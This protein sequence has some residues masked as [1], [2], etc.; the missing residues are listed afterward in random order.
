[1]NSYSRHQ[2]FEAKNGGEVDFSGVTT[3]VSAITSG[4]D[5]AIFVAE[6]AG[7]ILFSALEEVNTR[8]LR[9]TARSAGI[10]D[11]GSLLKTGN[12]LMY[13]SA[14]GAGSI[15]HLENLCTYSGTTF[16]ETNGGDIAHTAVKASEFLIKAT[17]GVRSLGQSRA[18]TG[19]TCSTSA[20][21]S[22]L[23]SGICL[24]QTGI[25]KVGAQQIDV[26]ALA[27][28]DSYGVVAFELIHDQQSGQV[29]GSQ[30]VEID[31]STAKATL[32][33]QPLPGRTLRGA[34]FVGGSLYAID[35]VADELL[36]ISPA[37]GKIIGTPKKLMLGSSPYDL[38][39]HSDLV[40]NREANGL[41]TDNN[42]WYALDIQNGQLTLRHT[43]T[44]KLSDN[45]LPSFV[46]A[47]YGANATSA[48]FDLIELTT[49][50]L[51][52]ILS[53]DETLTRKTLFNTFPGQPVIDAELGDLGSVS[54][55]DTTPPGPVPIT[56]D[57]KGDGT[58]VT[59]DW[60][61]YDE[62]QNGNDINHYTV[63]TSPTNFTN[64]SQAK[65]AGTTQAG[66][67][68][69]I[70]QN[71]TRATAIYVAVTATDNWNNVNNNVTATATT[72]QD[73]VPPL[74][75][76]N[77]T[78]TSNSNSIGLAWAPSPSS[79]IGFYRVFEGA[80]NLSGDLPASKTNFLVSNLL[81]E[82]GYTF[83]IVAV[84]KSKNE[85]SG[86]SILAATHLRNPSGVT[87]TGKNSSAEVRWIGV[88]P[89]NLVKAYNIYAEESSYTSVS[90]LKPRAT[91]PAN[92]RITKVA[93][94]SNGKTYYV[95]VTTVNISN[96]ESKGVTTV[97][98]VPQQDKLGPIL[99]NATIQG[100]VLQT[101]VKVT[102]SA[103][104]QV[105]ANDESGV[106]R[107]EFYIND[108]Q[109]PKLLKIDASSGPIYS[110]HWDIASVPDGN[111]TV[112]LKAYDTLANL[113]PLSTLVTVEYGPPAVPA[114]TS[115]PNDHVTK[116][117]QIQVVGTAEKNTKV[118][119]YNND[120]GV[121]GLLTVDSLGSFR[122]SL[123]L[124][125]GINL[126]TATAEG[127]GG[128]S[129][130][131]APVKV[132]LDDTIP[133]A[134]KGVNA[135]ARTQG[136]IQV[137]WNAVQSQNQIVYDLYRASKSFSGLNGA[138]KV[139]SADIGSTSYVDL[140]T[141]DG[142]YYYRVVAKNE[143]NT[144]SVP[145]EQ[146]LADSDR[147]APKALN[148]DYAST[149]NVDPITG[150]MAPGFVTVT[151]DLNEE[152]LTTPFF[153]IAPEKD[154]PISVSL[155][156]KSVTQY[157]GTFEIK[158]NTASGKA[159]AVFAARDKVG[160]RGSEIVQG[161]SI[162]IDTSGPQVVKLTTSPVA[163]IENSSSSPV[164]V[165]ATLT[166]S[167]LPMLTE[168]PLVKYKLSGVG[169]TAVDIKNLTTP[170]DRKIWNA[171]F[172]LPAD[173]G[174]N[175]PENINFQF[176]AKD[177][178]E[179]VSTAIMAPNIFQVYQGTLP[180]L[181]V[182]QGL[183]AV[184]LPKGEV[185]LSW[186]AV[187]EAAGYQLFRKDPSS[188]TFKK[189]G[190]VLTGLNYKDAPSV[191]GVYAYTVASV[192]KE[193][194]K[195]TLSAQSDPVT[196]SADSVA[197]NP[198]RNLVLDLTGYGVKAT[199]DEPSGGSA[200]NGKVTY[201]FYRDNLP[202]NTP[203]IVQGLTPIV[204]KISTLLA[205]DP[206]PSELDHAYGVTAVDG[207][208]NESNPSNTVYLNFQLLP[209]S[210][211]SILHNQKTYPNISWTYTGTAASTYRLSAY[212]KGKP[213]TL[214]EGSATSYIDQGYRGEERKY[215]VI[216]ID[217]AKAESKPRTLVLPKLTTTYPT[218]LALQR[219]V[220]NR[221]TYRVKNNGVE[222]ITN[223]TLQATVKG[224]NHLSTVFGLKSQ[225]ELPVVVIVGGS[226]ALEDQEDI[227]TTIS[228]KPRAGETVQIVSIEE[229]NVTTSAL[230]V[231][232][233]TKDMKHG[234]TGQV[235]FSLQNTSEV[236]T[237]VITARNTGK[238]ASDEVGFVLTDENSSVYSTKPLHQH[239]GANVITLSNGDTV[240]RIAPKA[241]FTSDWM[242]IDVPASAPP[243]AK[244]ALQIKSFHSNLSTPQ[245]AFIAGHGTERD[246]TLEQP[247]YYGKV[248][249]IV[250]I[251]SFGDKITI[252]GQGLDTNTATPVTFRPL[253]LI[254][255][256]SGFERKISLTTDQSGE[257]EY[258][259]EPAKVPGGLYTVS[260]V[261][262]GL[263][264]RPNQGQFTLHTLTLSE[265]NFDIRTAKN[266]VQPFDVTVSAGPAT[267]AKDVQLLY[268]A[269]DQSL[270][271]LPKGIVITLPDPVDLSPNQSKKLL[272]KIAGDETAAN[273]GQLWL[274]LVAK[275]TGNKVLGMLRVTYRF[276][277]ATPVIAFSP[278]FLETG[279]KHNST[280]NETVF[281]K[282][283]GLAP[284]LN[285]QI[286]LLQKSNLKPAP[287]WIYTTSTLNLTRLGVGQR[288]RV[289]L[290]IDP[291]QS[292]TEG[293]HEFLLRVTAPGETTQ[294]LRI[295]VAVTQKGIGDVL[296]HLSDIYTGTLNSKQVPIPGLAG[297]KVKI[298][299]DT[300][301][302]ISQ[303][304]YSDVNGE[305][306]LK[307]LPA[308]NYIVR[309]SAPD[310]QDQID[311]LNIRAGIT[312]PK[313]LFLVNVVVQVEWSIKEITLKD[314]Y[315]IILRAVFKTNVP[316]AVVVLEP[317][318][319]QLPK[320]KKGQIF[321]GE[322][323][324]TNYGL[325]KATNIT[326]KLPGSDNRAKYEFFAQMPKELL[327][328]ERVKIPYR[329]T[330]LRD[331]DSGKDSTASGGGNCSY[332]NRY[333]VESESTCTN[334]QV[335]K[336]NTCAYWLYTQECTIS[337]GGKGKIIGG[338]VGGGGGGFKPKGKS[339]P[340]ITCVPWGD[341]IE[342]AAEPSGGW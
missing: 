109:G 58:W 79:D 24:Q 60:K 64:T 234:A 147:T 162:L 293:Y 25:I 23:P 283:D 271:T 236:T 192:R 336:G 315:Q 101:G 168:D 145:S 335:V 288:H 154:V 309:A 22:L 198:P 38:S 170:G 308:G 342:E 257:F 243:K 107:V 227:E 240:A 246:V 331:F 21:F 202:P 148:I 62:K 169:R 212:D 266:Y 19:N 280:V 77:I 9:F 115:P 151:I 110:A 70:L 43:D 49:S 197:P 46:G 323:T 150:R 201:A 186:K 33:G 264:D 17:F 126:L 29:T 100:K 218:P 211:I 26:D 273:L 94:L 231:S 47:T 63:Y 279:A 117:K 339:L 329:V 190:A 251:S 45:T 2:L 290:V 233:E 122:T 8:N 125:D 164:Q 129:A 37:D 244:I 105:T 259:V 74:E 223:A 219:G 16:S 265:T 6:S 123:Q 296:F 56:I 167:E 327:P 325:I 298:Q 320:M 341:C 255:Q 195:E 142:R 241:T 188:S 185:D 136:E 53:T 239:L 278:S 138:T 114:I 174:A 137:S 163:P 247:E 104:I 316:I 143:V 32:T 102:R 220:F 71:L 216:A 203:I 274:R 157:Q 177:D 258:E 287:W 314:W 99:S 181:A 112:I 209:V 215:E 312:V 191:D 82:T 78:V 108:G 106:G 338:L 124:S 113:T 93:G 165:V 75:V 207:A 153:S 281:V 292:V 267:G 83:R 119:V 54:T 87:A 96:G 340:S 39:D 35:S 304:G 66:I 285:A 158:Q 300:I 217:A 11:F 97:T 84:D 248:L 12:Y 262:P 20:L 160:N 311:Y 221:L 224:T 161:D 305:L 91:V 204:D 214:Q 41:L 15:I 178:L 182:P 249:S 333:C 156:K 194:N 284:L 208:G 213:V 210:S 268:L 116:E 7:R 13:Y 263:L 310:H 72:P 294:D 270:K 324:L 330:A 27:V 228:I 176:S 28:S 206:N 69:F 229:A 31:H 139:N 95:A 187:G 238:N 103:T 282:N 14:D 52:Q 317:A 289:D 81:F 42:R 303:T 111:Y 34:T 51:D 48:T 121:G 237:E 256:T 128:K 225:E 120:I 254:L 222:D 89:Q 10:I 302:A 200:V 175:N 68:S 184:A 80:Q 189:L 334:R 318:G 141:S 242:Q 130:K 295:S 88:N 232:L 291:D 307:D 172:T 260:V 146:V 98:A 276:S 313:E 67:K 152:L 65:S 252:V 306:L 134:P 76:S 301:A 144:Q 36:Q 90:G 328:N 57:P 250:P 86:K 235:R 155:A 30:L 230:V 245:H 286:S 73:V 199:W 166:L 193:N 297:A 261:Y 196:V 1:M 85:S 319:V 159:Y 132:T 277:E 321:N 272:I 326:V 4:D 44:E 140:P 171:T 131:S 322:L 180:P 183:A 135:Y 173:A 50:T 205:L 275:D 253:E 18:C 337:G 59:V 92:G 118:Q 55:S 269:E 3:F 226:S 127:R 5:W 61:N 133:D 299:H 332:S 149:G 179:N 40:V